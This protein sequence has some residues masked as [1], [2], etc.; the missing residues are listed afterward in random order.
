MKQI[1]GKKTIGYMTLMI[2]GRR[3]EHF[4]ERCVNE[5]IPM[6]DVKKMKEK[7]IY[8]AKIYLH[9][10]NKVLQ[11]NERLPL[12]YDIK[13]V[14]KKGGIAFL[15]RLVKNRPVVVGLVV[16]LITLFLMS[17]IIWSVNI[18][19]VSQEIEE[20]I[21]KQLSAYGIHPGVIQ[22]SQE[23]LQII[24][25]NVLNDIPE[26]LWIGIEKRGTS[27]HIEGVEKKIVEQ[28]EPTTPRHLIAKKN[29]VIE[30][31]YIR[32]GLPLVNKFDYVKEGDL[33]VSG[34]IDENV[35]DESDEEEEE[36]QPPRAVRAT[37]E[38]FAN[39]WY[40]MTVSVPLKQQYDKLTGQSKTS[41]N[42]STGNIKIP[43]W[44]FKK[45]QFNNVYVE[46]NEKQITFLKWQLPISIIE[47]RT[48]E[49]NNT[50]I[51]RTK[52]EAIQVGIEQAKES[53]RLQLDKDAEI[54]SNFILH[55]AVENGKVKLNLYVS[56]LENIAVEQNIHT[57]T[58]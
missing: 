11:L 8:E 58:D 51:E 29:G 30:R 24:Q 45:R 23:P 49:L 56:V 18:N 14:N 2:K 3:V 25:Q 16:S 54:L 26:L 32:E 39:T 27:F 36:K 42:L 7:E 13:I 53:L 9:H 10:L 52:D 6:W 48:Y 22:F 17:N 57:K 15:Q 21:N 31:M 37:G 35:E 34:F 43:I 40:E 41:Y 44:G 38:V 50:E 1:Q 12:P 20:K 55:E 33:L 47:K 28:I 5:D 4:L 46:E 19:G